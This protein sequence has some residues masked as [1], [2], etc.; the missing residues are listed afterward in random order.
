MLELHRPT[1]GGFQLSYNT[2]TVPLW[3]H[4]TSLLCF[5][6]RYRVCIIAGDSTSDAEF[7]LFGRVAQQIICRSVIT[8]SRANPASASSLPKEIARLVG[9]QFRFNVSFTE[10]TLITG[11]ITFQVN[12]AQTAR[13][14]LPPP[15]GTEQ[16]KRQG[17]SIP[18]TPPHVTQSTSSNVA[19]VP[20]EPTS[21]NEVMIVSFVG[22]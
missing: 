10:N 16:N 19:S 17:Q 5:T 18:M 4:S 1:Q 15:P 14:A 2:S 21:P 22:Y 7:V 13:L 3:A 11:K 8:L 9:Q 12:S 20:P 6:C